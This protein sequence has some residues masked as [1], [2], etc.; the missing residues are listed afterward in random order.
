MSAPTASSALLACASFL[1]RE[2]DLARADAPFTHVKLGILLYYAQSWHLAIH[3]AKLFQDRFR[4][5]WAGPIL[6]S[7]LESA[8]AMSEGAEWSPVRR[9]SFGG[10]DA[11]DEAS[12]STLWQILNSYGELGSGRLCDLA[13]RE[14]P[15]REARNGLPPCTPLGGQISE[16][17]MATAIEIWKN[18]DGELSL[19]ERMERHARTAFVAKESKR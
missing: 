7:L 10:D 2:R 19:V 14:A 5:Y 11:I 16:A 1:V 4:A 3:A 15:W 8:G 17:S 12:R 6:P 9:D 18:D 13:R